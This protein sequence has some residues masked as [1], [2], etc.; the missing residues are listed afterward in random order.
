MAVRQ[1]RGVLLDHLGR[2]AQLPKHGNRTLGIDQLVLA[3]LLSFFDPAVRS[4]RIIEGRGNFQD[5]LDL[6]RC[7]RSTTA[8]ALKTFDPKLLCP[9]ID[10]LRQRVPELGQETD[11]LQKVVKKIV[12]ADGSYLTTIADALWALAHRKRD[13]KPQAQVRMNVQLETRSWIPQ[14][15][16]ISGDDNASE[17]AAFARDLL[18][19]VLYVLDRNFLDFLFLNELLARDNDFV[20]RLRKNAPS[21]RVLRTLTIRA[22]DAAAGVVQDQ[23]AQ[24]NSPAAPSG[25]F[26]LV[27][28]HT[29]GRD[30]Q[31]QVIR[32]L[33]NLTDQETSAATIGA[34]YRQRWQIELFFKWLKTWAQMGHLLST[35]RNGITF[36]LYVAVIAVLLMYVQSGRRVSRYAL[37]FLG[38]VAQGTMSLEEALRALAKLEREKDL[39]R[40][41]QAKRR[42]RKKLS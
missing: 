41:R 10:D 11:D 32:L 38:W 27:T 28:I 19:G 5:R 20:L 23:I 30:G 6:D 40:A 36:Q 26:R 1:P 21:L 2:L 8:E 14:V 7:A 9:L 33:T 42:A 4:L 31:C 29:T 37:A 15:I 18:S 17:P 16:S 25:T 22:E 24:L 39:A 35:S 13:G 34:I 3:M 12:A